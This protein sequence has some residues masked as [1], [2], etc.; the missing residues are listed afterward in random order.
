MD[1]QELQAH[2][3]TVVIV[4]L[5]DIK[6]LTELQDDQERPVSQDSQDH[7][8]EWLQA[9]VSRSQST[10]RAHAFRLARLELLHSGQDTLFFMYKEMVDQVDKTLVRPLLNDFAE[11]RSHLRRKVRH[12]HV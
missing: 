10:R 8:E 12:K 3:D 11:L 7:Q 2:L 1:S 9:V 5:T 4:D 6:E